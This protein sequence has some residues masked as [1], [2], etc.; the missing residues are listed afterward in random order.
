MCAT[1]FTLSGFQIFYSVPGAKFV[2]QLKEAGATTNDDRHIHI[3]ESFDYAMVYCEEILLGDQEEEGVATDLVE[4]MAMVFVIQV[5]VE[6]I[7]AYFT[8]MELASGETII[9]QGDNAD[10]LYYLQS[11]RLTVFLELP[12]GGRRRLSAI[13]E[14]TIMGEMGLYSGAERSTTVVADGLCRI[15]HLSLEHF[16]SMQRDDPVLATEL[17]RYV[18]RLLSQRLCHAVRQVGSLT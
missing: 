3:A 1:F 2:S 7:R 17:D 10:G 11:G 18:I 9:H 12:D 15:F 13:H 4:E 5:N 8:P 6:R 14:G 16:T